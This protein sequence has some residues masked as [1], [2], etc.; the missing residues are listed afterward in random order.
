MEYKRICPKCEKEIQY[1]SY[2]AWYNANKKDTLCRSCS[3][4]VK[5][6]HCGDLKKLLEENNE[7]YYWIGFL[8]ADGSFVNGRLKFCLA[9]KDKE[10]V[11]KFAK[12]INYTGTILES[13]NSVSISVKDIDIVNKICEK[14]NILP[15]KTYNPPN[16]LFNFSNDKL[17]CILAGFIDGDGCIQ[18]QYRRED[19]M[20][21]IKNHSSW[22]SV[23]K[24]FSKLITGKECVKINSSGYAEL[25][26]TNTK[27]LQNLKK[28]I[29]SYNIPI[30]ERKWD[31]IDLNFVSKYTKAEELRLKVLDLLN[32]N[33]K[34]QDIAKLCN[35][36]AANVS[37]IKKN[38]YEVEN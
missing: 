20:L 15:R 37:K 32:K 22:E 13:N 8:L 26:I 28:K 27:D 25:T 38:Y 12:F 1:K 3:A 4:K 21:R 29:I 10:Q 35:T 18:K 33:I 30:L 23:L 24:N 11:Y 14:F 9:E 36:S 19:F 2:S 34:Q 6:P 17:Y 7:A 31:I 5:A 16:N